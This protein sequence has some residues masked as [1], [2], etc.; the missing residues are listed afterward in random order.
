MRGHNAR[1][2][3]NSTE[4]MPAKARRKSDSGPTATNPVSI[5]SILEGWKAKADA[6]I[7]SCHS[8]A[9]ASAGA[10]EI[11]GQ[12]VRAQAI[13]RELADNQRLLHECLAKGIGEPLEWIRDHPHDCPLP[14][15]PIEAMPR[16]DWRMRSVP[17]D[18][19]GREPTIQDPVDFLRVIAGSVIPVWIAQFNGTEAP[20]DGLIPEAR[21]FLAAMLEL[22]LFDEESRLGQ[23]EI[24]RHVG[25]VGREV[26]SRANREAAIK[27]LKGRDFIRSKPN[28]G[29]MLT[30][31]GLVFA[32]S[33]QSTPE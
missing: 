2:S 32:R 26:A 33:M 16:C 20:A 3:H 9:G 22:G 21:D 11:R 29:T 13:L 1:M 31:A 10:W 28:C 4:L 30:P 7:A 17:S 27:L 23:D 8:P 19:K 14:L 18:A 6:H 12:R 24:W 5:T 15:R 25:E